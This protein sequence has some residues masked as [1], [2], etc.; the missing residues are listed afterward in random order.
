MLSLL[1]PTL[2]EYPPPFFA[3]HEGAARLR[4]ELY[5]EHPGWDNMV[6]SIGWE[7]I[8]ISSVEGAEYARKTLSGQRRCT[9][10]GIRRT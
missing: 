10:V 9:A 1:P 7:R 4:E 8:L 3:G 2:A 5:R 6:T